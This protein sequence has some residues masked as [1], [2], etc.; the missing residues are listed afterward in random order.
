[1]APVLLPSPSDELINLAVLDVRHISSLSSII[2]RA[3]TTVELLR[4]QAT[5]AI[6]SSTYT[7]LNGGPTPGAVVGAVLGSVGGFLLILWLLYTC[8]GM[9]RTTASSVASSVVVRERRKSTRTSS[10]QRSR[11]QSETAEIRRPPVVERVVVEER[12]REREVRSESSGGEDEV[13]VIEEH[14]PPRTKSKRE[15]GYRTVDPMAYGGGDRPLREVGRK[16]SSRR[17]RG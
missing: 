2:R 4:R 11:R 14:S 3:S 5:V 12:R 10:G 9:T 16:S 8:F 6:P 7:G 17:S 1:M 13:V 15:S